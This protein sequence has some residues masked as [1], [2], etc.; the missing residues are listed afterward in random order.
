MPSTQIKP[1][2][3][4]LKLE[5]VWRASKKSQIKSNLIVLEGFE[6]GTHNKKKKS[7]I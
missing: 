3:S 5:R 7:Q 6:A 2:W 1:H 4:W